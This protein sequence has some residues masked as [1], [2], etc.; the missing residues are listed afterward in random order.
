MMSTQII[1]AKLLFPR[2]SQRTLP[3][4]RIQ[5][6]LAEMVDY[7]LAILQAGAGYGKSTALA[8]FAQEQAQVVWIHL[9][10]ESGDPHLFLQYLIQGCRHS[11][12]AISQTPLVLLEEKTEHPLNDNWQP[13]VNSLLNELTD[14][15]PNTLLV[16]DD[17]HYLNHSAQSSKIL[18]HLIDLAPS[19]LQIALTTRYPLELPSL[20]NWRVRGELLEIGQMELAFT[21]S[22]INS[23]FQQH[24]QL[25]LD[26]DDLTLLATQSEGWA[27][28]LQMVAQHLQRGDSHT[29]SQTLAHLADSDGDLF[30]F[31]AQEVVAQQPLDIQTFLLETGVLHT[32]TPTFCDAYRRQKDSSQILHYLAENGLFVTM[33]GENQMRY[34]PL[35]HDLLCRQLPAGILQQNH[36]RAGQCYQTLGQPE[37]AIPHLLAAEAYDNSANLLTNIGRQMLLAGRLNRLAEWI[38][39]LPLPILSAYPAL[40]IYLGDIARYHSHFEEALG[41]Y[42][43]AEQLYRKRQENAGISHALRGQAR[44]YLDTVN[45][46]QAE[47]LLQEALRLSDGQEDRAS[48]TRLLELLAENA[49][50]QGR[51]SDAASFQERAKAL[52][53]EGPGEAEL[54]VRMQ[55]R[56]G[57]LDEARQ[58]LEKRAQNEEREPIHRPRAHRE[59]LLLLSL[60]LSFQGEQEAAYQTAI[61]GTERGQLLDSPFVTAVGYMRQGHSWLTLKSAEGYARAELLFQQA[62]ALSQQIDVPRLKVEAAWGLCQAHGFRGQLAQAEGVVA[63][64]G[65]IAMAAGDEWIVGL[66][67]LTIGASYLLAGQYSSADLTLRE[68]KLIFQ[69]C[70]DAFGLTVTHLWRALL[71]LR[72]DDAARLGRELAD[73]LGSAQTERYRF[74]FSKRTLLGPPDPAMMIPLLLAAREM[75]ASHKTAHQLLTQ[76]GLPDLLYHPGYQLRIQTLGRFRLWRGAEDVPASAWKRQHARKLLLLFLTHHHKMLE[77]EQIVDLLWREAPIER[78]FRDFKSAYNSLCNLLEPNR[79]RNTPSAYILRDGSQYGWR[80][81]AD[82][83]LDF[84]GFQ[85]HL[86]QGDALW[87]SEPEKA[88]GHYENGLTLYAGNFLQEYPYEEWAVE[89]REHLLTRY[90]RTAERV[91]QVQT[92]QA[93][94][95]GVIVTCEAILR[96]DS[97]WEQAYRLLMTAYHQLDNRPQVIRVY[98]R[99]RQLLQDELGIAPSESTISLLA[100]LRG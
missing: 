60:I 43:Q 65:E 48:Q 73:L 84:L 86:D 27:I 93:N 81:S 96:Y 97:C 98:R 55:L 18:N 71:W 24:Y 15:V 76:L 28:A 80:A 66:L 52:L 32:L 42:R 7:R 68:A 54:S 70:A 67:K 10:L 87:Q 46:S 41:W 2:P 11:L 31:L 29:L 30:T 37:A 3:R 100:Q 21:L 49:L 22:E 5:K 9:D 6:R 14:I 62:I 12:P 91:A 77:R 23:L 63:M 92:A 79:K 44:V 8:H 88:M 33:I 59:T 50:N 82:V 13:I 99:C 57:L 38:G 90:L 40:L 26:S 74:L 53:T 51:T 25:V 61:A 72:L 47:H 85:Q 4:L 56:T 39:A 17:A 83:S 64:G 16:F 69:N 89:M 95:E 36:L 1:R 58:I 78:A 75:P 34:H 45:P 35:F 94:W 20:V 19:H